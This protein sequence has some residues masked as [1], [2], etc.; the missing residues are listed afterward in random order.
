[1]Q[2]SEFDDFF[3]S[4]IVCALWPS[5]DNA[6]DSGSEP[7]DENYDESD[8]TLGCRNAMR[9]DCA[10][11][12]HAAGPDLEGLDPGQCGHDFWLTRNGHGAGFWDRGLGA[13]GERLT[14]AAKEFGSVD[15]YVNDD[16]KVDA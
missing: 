16:G 5:T 8:L 4:Y 9:A 1:M 15:L 3:S 7:L 10:A 11:F 13:L 12:V 14:K 6:D 2:D